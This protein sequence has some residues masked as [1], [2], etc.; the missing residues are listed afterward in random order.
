MKKITNHFRAIVAIVMMLCVAF[1]SLAHDFEVGGIYYN[2]TSSTAKT[3][4]VT[5]KGNEYKS[6]SDEY[7][8]SVTIPS[9]V[10]Y[11]GTTYSVTSI[12]DY[13]F[14]S[15][16][17][18]T[19]VTIG[20]SVTSIGDY[21]FY[22]CSGLTSVTIPNSVISIGDY[23]FCS[24][25]GLTSVTIGNSVT[26][27]GNNAFGT[28]LGLTEVN[29]NAKNCTSMGSDVF[30]ICPNFKTLNIGDKVKT[31]PNYAFY[32][33]DNLTTVTI[34]NSVTSIGDSAFK[35]CKGLTSVTI[36]NSV[37]SIGD[38]AFY[39][40]TGLT[41]VTIGNSVRSIGS[42]AFKSCSN[43]KIVVNFSNL[44]FSKGSSNYGYIAC[45]AN[46]VINAPNGSIV[47]DCVFYKADNV[48]ILVVYLGNATE[49]ILPTE[50]NGGNYTIGS[51]AFSGCSGLTTVTIPNS[52]TKI[53]DWAFYNCK[54]LTEVNYNAENCTSMGSSSYPV[55]SGCSSLKTLNIGNEVNTIPNSAFSGCSG[56][57][58]VT[59]PNSVTTIGSEAFS[60][61]SGLTEVNYN[62]ENC[63]S[64][65]SSSYP[66]FSGCSS[67]KTLN[68]GNEVK[69]IPNYAFSGCSGL[70]EVNYNAENCTSMGSSSY[71]VFSGCS[72]LKTLNIGNEVKTIPKYAFY[73]CSG[74]TSVTIGNSVTSIGSYAFYSCLGL[75]SVTI[76]NS[77]T[78]IDN[79]AFDGC[80]GLTTVNYNAENCTSMGS[81]S[82][83]VFSGCSRL[84][85]LNIGNEV[86]TIPSDAFSGCTSL[87]SVT[88]GN[89]V[90]SIGYSAFND[91]INLTEVN[92]SDLS[93]WCKIYFRSFSTNPLYY[94][95]KL[96]L[97]GSE[98]TD[99]VIP[100]D[101]TQINDYAF[102]G[103]SNLTSVT[104]PNSVTSIGRYAF[105]GC[106]G[107]TEVT[108]PN[109]VTSIG[110]R[111]FNGTAWYNNQAD[112]VLYINNVLYEYKGTMQK[113]TSI[114]IKEGT[115]S[116]SPKAFSGCSGLN[117]VVIPNS[118]TAIGLS[119]FSGCSNLKNIISLNENPP[120]CENNSFDSEN[121]TNSTLY[122]PKD[123]YA[124]YFINDVWGQ[125][126]NI[127]KLENLV[128]NISIN[129][130]SISLELGKTTTLSATVLPSSATFPN[131]YWES[132]N[133]NVATVDQTGKV[134][135]HSKG[136]AIITAKSMDGSNITASCVVKVFTY[137]VESITLSQHDATLAI[138]DKVTLKYTI[139]PSYVTDNSVTWSNSNPSVASMAKNSDGSV[140]ISCQ[141]E[142]E[143][144]IKVTTNDGTNLSDSCKITVYRIPPTITL[145]KTSENLLIH[146]T[147]KL[148]YTITN[149][150]IN[151]AT[152][153]TSDATVASITSNTDGSVTVFAEA[154]G[155]ATITAIM[156]DVNG[157]EF[158]ATC[159]ITVIP[160]TIV[161]SQTV[162]K[163][164]VNELLTLNYDIT[165][166]SIKNAT[167]TTSNP[168]VAPIKVNSDGSVIVVG[169]SEGVAIITA[170]MTEVNGVEYSASCEVTVG[171]SGVEGIETDNN[172]KEVARYDIHG[173]LLSE[174]TKG[175][176]IIK[177]SDG[178]TRKE[179]VK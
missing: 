135:A 37:T 82:Y 128:S 43:L 138:K 85:T 99:L 154:E 32:Y 13:A 78:S 94:A 175:I 117:E 69:T 137:D 178:S 108:I 179:I 81:S 145:S 57:T 98:V 4:A 107:L 157:K 167:W 121:Y 153:S 80:T 88:I 8:G 51:E 165:N 68:I 36:P 174:P 73:S 97:N 132:N 119:A 65:G 9:S 33:C 129:S 29:Y 79:G 125:F 95:G 158:S 102:Y 155:V 161:L 31:I 70:T 148:K 176:N 130:S 22:S 56:L 147:V 28:C 50:F 10:T 110:D 39:F 46:Q 156:I 101:V 139:T 66:V 105:N 40:C 21:A 122:V 53:G 152:W 19:S 162:A 115:I 143:T 126:N 103:C 47:K 90:T 109:S 49:L 146:N 168:D 140:T 45:Y 72:S 136:E 24:C 30:S 133:E 166:S 160:P 150:T 141:E 171:I 75:T 87:T 64:M 6:Y 23:A 149:S 71:P 169:L 54:G 151:T 18:L 15:C 163:L 62:A 134:T 77:V 170:T 20:N 14:Y 112:G 17:G 42:E 127:V 26:S 12:G 124:K 104:I 96:K 61:C 63:T 3:V 55:F 59:I 60:G 38:Y 27:I 177:M 116:I 172:S 84:K 58:T 83:P 52:V 173:R 76:G 67:L 7:T 142:G 123:S 35:Y 113:G 144:I 5:Y 164:P 93:A 111:A 48:N 2:I 1:P 89:S 25:S 118:V 114:S 100:N 74:L 86:K 131:L 44:T 92:I 16:S 34:P 11:S 41:S 106:R 159:E 120:T 91:C